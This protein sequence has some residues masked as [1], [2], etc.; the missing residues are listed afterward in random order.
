MLFISLHS[1]MQSFRAA[2]DSAP[3]NWAV[4]VQLPE[5]WRLHPAEAIAKKGASPLPWSNLG[6]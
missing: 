1:Y 3:V 6:K 2:P 5:I 4:P